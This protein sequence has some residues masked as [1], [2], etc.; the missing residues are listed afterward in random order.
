MFGLGGD[1]DQHAGFVDDEPTPRDQTSSE[2]QGPA[3]DESLTGETYQVTIDDTERA[4]QYEIKAHTEQAGPVAGKKPRRMFETA[5]NDPQQSLWIGYDDTAR[6]GFREAPIQFSA[7]RRHLWISG[8]T[9]SGKTTQMQNKAVQH[10]YAGHGF[11]NIDPKASGDTIELLQ[12]LPTHRLDDVIVLDP[13]SPGLEKIVGINMLDMPAI[14][15]ETR[16]EKEIESRLENLVAIFDNDEYWGVNMQAV[17]ESMGRAMLRHNAEISLDPA[18]DPEDK[19]S[20]ID[21]YFVLLNAERRE[22]FATECN[23]P[24]LREFLFEIVEMDDDD[25]RPLTKRIKSWVENAVVRR[26]ISRRESTI[27]WDDIVDNDRILLVRIPVDSED[28]HQM[29]SLSVLRNLWSAK[30]RQDRD[31]ERETKPYFLQVDEFEKVANDNLAIE[32]MLVRARSMWL[33]VTLGTQYPGQIEQDHEGVMRAMENNCN[34]LLAMRTPGGNDAKLLM[35]RFEGYSAGDLMDTNYYRTWTKIPLPGGRESE[36]VNLQNFAPYPPLRSADE[37]KNVIR[38]T[39]DRWGAEPLSD[40]EIQRNLKYG[41]FNEVLDPDAAS[42]ADFNPDTAAFDEGGLSVED[43]PTDTILEGIYAAQVQ[44]EDEE[45]L[46]AATHAVEEVEKRLGDTGYQSQ[47]SNAFEELES[48]KRGRRSGE[49]VVGLT[50][51]GRTRVFSADTG[52]SASGG[53]DDHRYILQESFRAFTRLGALTHL[54]TQE[55]DELPDGVADL[56]IDP[57]ADADTMAEAHELETRLQSEYPALYNLAGARD[58]AIEAETSTIK[59]PMQTLTN[60]R[61]AIESD[62]LCVYTCKDA[63]ASGNGFTYWPQRGEKIIFDVD[64][65]QIDY[66]T[67]TCV[68]DVDD[69]GRRTFYNKTSKY[70]IDADS[71]AVRPTTKERN[72][73]RWHEADDDIVATAKNG[74]ECGRFDSAEAVENPSPSEVRAYRTLTDDGAWIVQEGSKQHG[75]YGSLDE[76]RNEWQDLYAPFIPENE[77]PRQP[78]PDDFVFVVFPDDD[79]TE[80][81]EPM[82][83]DQGEIRP[84]FEDDIDSTV[85]ASSE[86]QDSTEPQHQADQ[87]TGANKETDRATDLFVDR[88]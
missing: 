4:G 85:I 47:L 62:R 42:G 72:P 84:L 73:L 69:E 40:D 48:V 79:N 1:D 80:F 14:E 67:I 56:P 57:L 70:Q 39:L 46:V 13:G 74:T 30:K 37:A 3:A 38:T 29:I 32:D 76:L 87:P 5:A 44:Y 60:L 34:S 20:V 21:M 28:V 11:C 50:P 59:K 9:G 12:Q 27:D 24:Y 31:P 78:V 88:V 25:L 54:P 6:N 10:A 8:T 18:G 82:L 71:Y 77:F 75:P 63:T 33:S 65:Q 52:S 16:R 53:G 36:P 58:I 23:D 61:K 55:G 41:G 17:T 22:R 19:Y 43:L 68:R 15:D 83:Y 86:G 26:I 49:V 35:R 7:L 64:G 45:T 2:Q 51:E 66:K 81:D